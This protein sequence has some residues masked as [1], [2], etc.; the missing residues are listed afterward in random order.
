MNHKKPT[1]RVAPTTSSARG[2]S[3]HRRED[4]YQ[5][6][7]TN[8]AA[9]ADECK[10]LTA[11]A[12]E[13]CARETGVAPLAP[14]DFFRLKS[15]LF[16][17][18]EAA[19]AARWGSRRAKLNKSL[20][21][22][23]EVLLGHGHFAFG[24]RVAYPTTALAERINA[25]ERTVT[26]VIAKLE[27]WP[28]LVRIVRVLPGER[29]WDGRRAFRE[30]I[31]WELGPALW[32]I[33]ASLLGRPP[34]GRSTDTVTLNARHGA[35]DTPG[36]VPPDQLLDHSTDQH[37][38]STTTVLATDRPNLEVSPHW[39]GQQFQPEADLSASSPPP[40]TTLHP[41]ATKSPSL[42]VSLPS[43]TTGN[44]EA[45]REIIAPRERRQTGSHPS[46]VDAKFSGPNSDLDLSDRS[47]AHARPARRPRSAPCIEMHAL[48]IAIIRQHRTIAEHK[49]PA[50]PIAQD[51]LDVVGEAISHLPEGM[52]APDVLDLCARVSQL[53]ARD[54]SG[55]GH[56]RATL[57]FTFG[58]T[59]D[60][61]QKF[62]LTRVCRVREEREQL[63]RERH[64]AELTSS[65]LGIRQPV[66]AQPRPG[67]RIPS[68]AANV[69]RQPA[70][71]RSP[72]APADLYES[73]QKFMAQAG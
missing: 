39:A 64:D 46:R 63:Q 57:R 12:R 70:E 60:E 41:R 8:L 33:A 17:A 4:G 25:D 51:E 48:G 50:T 38:K 54:S 23:V 13:S 3:L 1:E 56:P 10:P 49:G 53:A 26:R 40:T 2:S 29:S 9:N 59:E 14:R 71:L 6:P 31:E 20:L 45:P 11:A 36:K 55:K 44:I 37:L 7:G 62:F 42:D 65:L 30:H 19:F 61:P 47:R 69:T 66:K 22:L 35:S 67:G 18:A 27:H 72:I 5:T 21:R 16:A 43:A 34:V 24:V 28:E 58:G 73:I 68:T 52:S 15:T 32:S